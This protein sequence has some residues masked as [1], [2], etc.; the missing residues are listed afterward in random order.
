MSASNKDK[1]NSS[2]NYIT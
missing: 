2:T 1:V